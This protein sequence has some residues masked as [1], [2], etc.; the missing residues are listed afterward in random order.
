[1]DIKFVSYTGSF[2]NLCSGTLT[3]EIDKIPYV[4][5]DYDRYS[6]FWTSGGHVSFDNEWNE[7]VTQGE[8]ELLIWD[9][10]RF[11][12]FLIGHEDELLEVFNANVSHGCCGGCV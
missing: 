7:C 5:G 9:R 3:L 8:W 11:P 6:R 1:M 2:P 4:F 10:A 12:E